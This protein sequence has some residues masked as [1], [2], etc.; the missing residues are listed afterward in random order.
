MAGLRHATRRTFLKTVGQAGIGVAALGV[1]TEAQP[2]T[3][4]I[5]NEADAILKRIVPPTFPNRTFDITRY[6]AAAGRDT[7]VTDAFRAAIEACQK[8][9]GGRVVVPAGRF[10][11]GPIVLRSNVNLH[12][13]EGA[14]VAFTPDARAYLPVVFTRY[15]GVEFMNYSPFVYAFEQ[16]NIAITGPG[17]LDGQADAANW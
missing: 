15:E 11:T 17:T 4:D 12:L 8:A 6:G 16:Q 2:T 9:G 14:V 13:S 7:V 3:L 1:R 10:V 5:W